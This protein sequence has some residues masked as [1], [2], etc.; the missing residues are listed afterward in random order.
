MAK[1]NPINRTN[2]VRLGVLIIGILLLS[3][4]ARFSYFLCLTASF[5]LLFTGP[6]I[7]PKEF[8]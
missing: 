8:S 4:M 3:V 1:K 5:S 7:T 6:Y 2:K